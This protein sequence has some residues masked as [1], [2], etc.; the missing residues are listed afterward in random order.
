LSE[1]AAAPEPA[2]WNRTRH[3]ALVVR[4]A[5]EAVAVR[6]SSGVIGSIRRECLD[7]VVVIGERHRLG[8]LMS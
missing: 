8:I 7:H 4:E 2:A 6:M 5:L 3:T 1:Y